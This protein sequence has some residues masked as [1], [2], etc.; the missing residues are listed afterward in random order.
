MTPVLEQVTGTYITVY[1]EGDR[2]MQGQN[3]R[4]WIDGIGQSGTYAF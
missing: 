1:M 2:Q 3:Q 4:T